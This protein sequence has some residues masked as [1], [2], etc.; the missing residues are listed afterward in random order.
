MVDR[1]PG[2]ARLQWRHF[3][4][5]QTDAKRSTR[6]PS[7]ER[8][9]W[10]WPTWRISA[11][12]AGRGRCPWPCGLLIFDGLGLQSGLV[13]DENTRE[14]AVRRLQSAVQAETERTATVA[15]R[16]QAGLALW[17]ER[18][19]TDGLSYVTD[20]GMLVGS[21]AGDERPAGAPWSGAVRQDASQAAGSPVYLSVT[22]F[23]PHLRG[24]KQLLEE[25]ARYNTVGKLRNLRWDPGRIAEALADRK[26][27]DRAGQLLD[28]VAQLQPPAAYLAEAQANLPASHP[29]SE[30]ASAARIDLLNRVRHLA[31]AGDAAAAGVSPAGLVR[32][33]DELKREYVA[34]Y[35]DLHRRLVL[36][37]AADDRRRRLYDDPRL[38]ALNALSGLDLLNRAEL[39][40]WKATATGLRGVPGIPRGGVDRDANLPALRPAPI[41]ATC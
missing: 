9:P 24:Y 20:G 39:D 16:L 33:M 15:G 19:F 17:N 31:A 26:W 29:W 32:E 27:A 7:S 1:H 41:A 22:D 11:S 4:E 38:A 3:A 23:L 40:A 35:A 10:R 6:R 13:R 37:P 2:R 14:D 25:L 28:L 5:R 30:R 36:G 34:A 8:R 18:V 12:M 21:G